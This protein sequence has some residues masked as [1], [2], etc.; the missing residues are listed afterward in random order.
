[1]E[2][3]TIL[4]LS[5]ILL[6]TTPQQ[7]NIDLPKEEINIQQVQENAIQNVTSEERYLVARIVKCEMVIN[8]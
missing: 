7:I 8:L 5:A 6:S 1:M 3:L 4:I 2:N